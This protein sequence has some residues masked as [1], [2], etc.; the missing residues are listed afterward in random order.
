[1]RYMTSLLDGV[2]GKSSDREY[3][4]A[5]ISILD[6]SDLLHGLGKDAEKTVWMSHGDRIDRMPR[7]FRP[8]RAAP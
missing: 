8:C 4:N 1:M 2:V 6:D 3:G 7:G 5:M